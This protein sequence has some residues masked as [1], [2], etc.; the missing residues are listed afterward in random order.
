MVVCQDV[1][2]AITTLTRRDVKRVATGVKEAADRSVVFMFPGQGSQYANMGRELYET[3]PTFRQYVDH[4]SALLGPHLSLDLR[5]WLYP[6]EADVE[7]ATHELGTDFNELTTALFVVEYALA[8][9]WMHWGLHPQAMIGH[10]IG[11]YVAACLAG[12]LFFRRRFG[13]GCGSGTS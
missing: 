12:V 10:S 1:D 7:T 6:A 2:D 5:K 9:L 8:Q 4:G 3:E 13:A 11:E